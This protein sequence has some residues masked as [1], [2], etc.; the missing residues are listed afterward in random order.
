ML[1]APINS[2]LDGL[3][4]VLRIRV[5]RPIMLQGL[6]ASCEELIPSWGYKKSHGVA[7]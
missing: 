3:A 7:G 6:Q 5:D 4:Q 2:V 1:V